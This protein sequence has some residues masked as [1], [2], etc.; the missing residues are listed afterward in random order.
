MFIECQ[1]YRSNEKNLEHNWRSREA[2]STT[3]KYRR[4]QQ[5]SFH[6]P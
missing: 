6:Q 2:T 1:P 3:N 5:G 4:K